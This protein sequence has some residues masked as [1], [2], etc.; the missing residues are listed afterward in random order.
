MNNVHFCS[1]VIRLKKQKI[2]HNYVISG[3]LHHVQHIIMLCTLFHMYFCVVTLD[4]TYVRISPYITTEFLLGCV[5]ILKRSIKISSFM[6]IL[7]G[8]YTVLDIF[9]RVMRFH[10]CFT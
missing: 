10:S 1:Y 9:Y 2:I 5:L 8:L 6:I 4:K 7:K 3:G